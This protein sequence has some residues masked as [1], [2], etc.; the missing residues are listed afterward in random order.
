MLT[1]TCSKFSGSASLNESANMDALIVFFKALR[2]QDFID[3]ALASY[4][5]FRFYVLFRGTYVFRVISGLALLWIFQ[6]ITAYMGL[7]VTSWAL[8]GIT[9]VA[10]FIII[11]VFRNELR[12]VLQAKNIKNILWGVSQKTSQAPVEIIVSGIFE[13][14]KRQIGALLV[15]PGS[16][17]I[18]EVLENGIAWEGKITQEMILSIFWHDNPVHD[19]A[20]IIEGDEVR[21]VGVILPLSHRTD[22]PSHFGTR[23]RAAVGMAEKSDALVVVVSEERKSILVVKGGELIK[24]TSPDQLSQLLQRHMGVAADLDAPA[25]RRAMRLATAG[26][27]SVL[28]VSGLWFSFTTGK[29][30]LIEL[31]VPIRYN[32]RAPGTEIVDASVNSVNLQLSGSG[33]LIQ[34]LR[35]GQVQ[36]QLDLQ[37]AAVGTNEFTIT[38]SNISLPPGIVLKTVQPRQVTVTLDRLVRKQ[39]PVQVD[40]T[41]KLP[42]D[43]ILESVRVMPETVELEGGNRIIENTETVY[44]QK[45]SLNGL[46]KSG[47][48]SVGL[49]L[50][51]A[52]LKVA[53]G[54][55]EKVTV[56]Y[57]I[58]KRP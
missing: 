16:D 48:L 5:L 30:T 43:R 13:L 4:I 53:P 14:M 24:V 33:T 34:S 25:S 9:A 27:L 37:S 19:G 31:Q 29:D 15:F 23:H 26:A 44:T 17:D 6:R 42:A 7:I 32:N 21:K 41:G 38:G 39:L 47:T 20:A 46:E 2:W 55:P 22:L 51:P 58:H 35:P 56:E 1:A 54:S 50:Q 12:S 28:L 57:I 45:V 40:W 8:Q 10:A 52:S 36:V 3:I 18:G 49:A 11:V